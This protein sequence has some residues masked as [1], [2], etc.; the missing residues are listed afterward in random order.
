[1]DRIK[2]S[3]EG[4]PLFIATKS[5]AQGI[6][7]NW[8]TGA[9]V[10]FF[11]SHAGC[12][13]QN[14]TKE[15]PAPDYLVGFDSRQ[16]TFF[17]DN[18]H[19]RFSPDNSKILFNS[20]RL[21]A[22]KG[23][24]IYE[25]DL[26]THRER[27]VTFS[28]GDAFDAS[29]I[30]PNEFMYA[31][32]TDEIKESPFRHRANNNEIPPSDLYMSDLYGTEILRLTKQ[33]GFDGSP[34]LFPHQDKPFIIFSSRRGELYGIYRLDLENL[35]VRLISAEK[36]KEK[37]Y[38]TLSPDG[39]QIVWIERN[40]NS[41]EQSLVIYSLKTRSTKII[42]RQPG[43]YKDLFYAPRSP[44]R[45]FYSVQHANQSKYQIE[46]YDIEKECTQVVFKGAD[47][48][49]SPAVSN[50]SSER[51]T[52]ARSFQDKKQIYIARMPTD[53]GPCLETPAQATLKK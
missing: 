1:M 19:P 51:V 14:T 36:G 48:L 41:L 33:P 38:P 28:D 23:S 29:Y 49:Y 22:H 5:I 11:L 42:P 12:T 53:L 17:G 43:D 10:G 37:K 9:I 35:P 3:E 4:E 21:S 15:I 2:K 52:F 16:L 45:L 40:L 31:S 7:M 50:E 39:N 18:D 20:I 44:E 32:T 26:T 6:G 47:D 8:I 24:Q 27:R 30:S 25:I 34:L 46:V 13:H